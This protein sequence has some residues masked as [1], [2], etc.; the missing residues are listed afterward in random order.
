MSSSSAPILLGVA[1]FALLF[2]LIA[3]FHAARQ[4]LAEFRLG[5]EERV[6]WKSTSRVTREARTLEPALS[7][8]SS[9]LVEQQATGAAAQPQLDRLRLDG[10]SKTAPEH[11]GRESEA[12][13][14]RITQNARRQAR[15]LLEQAE[16]DAKRIVATAGQALAGREKQL[17]EERSD[18][19]RRT[20]LDATSAIQE[21]ARR[22]EELLAAAEQQRTSLVREAEAEAERQAAEITACARQQAR[23]LLEA[24]QLEAKEI[25]VDTGQERAR[26][27][28]DVERERS[29]L[30]ETRTKLG[31]LEEATRKAEEL[32]F[33]DEQRREE[34][35]RRSEAEAER[36]A[37]DISDRARRRANELLEEAK[38]EAE[39]I[40][41]A[42]GEER[43][44]LVAQLA[45]ERSILEETRT[46]LSGFLTDVLDEVGAKSTTSAEPANV[47]DLEEA[48]AVRTST[49]ADH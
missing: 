49:R 37:A 35:R 8:P 9:T 10:G 15:E 40:I 46:R 29:L 2:V 4:W 13:A 33:A 25:V 47:R 12:E 30:E 11:L 22:A 1:T 3:G 7:A 20:R 34:H 17:D 38:V 39:R 44:R 5:R 45:D 19:E 26:L 36:K 14:E 42:A 48:R 21:A 43:A 27:L 28:S 6:A 41:A 31:S 32:F 23:E 16:I 18:L 24:A